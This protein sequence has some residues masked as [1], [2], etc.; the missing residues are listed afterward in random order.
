MLT[1]S[2]A[3]IHQI[4]VLGPIVLFQSV[5]EVLKASVLP[6]F[7]PISSVGGSLGMLAPGT[8]DLTPYGTSKAALNWVARKIHYENEWLGACFPWC[9]L[10]MMLYILMPLM[11]AQWR[12]RSVLDPWTPTWV[13]TAVL[14]VRHMMTDIYLSINRDSATSSV[15]R[16]GR[17]RAGAAAE[18]QH[19]L[20]RGCGAHF[21]GH[22]HGVDA[23][24]GRGAV[25]Q[26]R[27]YQGR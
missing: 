22:H 13:R 17:Q 27:G 20:A 2:L 24:E 9:T 3:Y 10:S 25:C 12:S 23:R 1:P 7:V 6:R 5:R 14:S 19:A 18:E 16:R 21:G 4:N 8:L 15:P 26:Y 11:C